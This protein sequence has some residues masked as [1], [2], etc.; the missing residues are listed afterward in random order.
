MNA[1]A[2]WKKITFLIV[3][4]L[5]KYDAIGE[6]IYNSELEKNLRISKF[7]N[8]SNVTTRVEHYIFKYY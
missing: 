2:S 8:H 7:I 3:M 1:K 6:K 4:V 5:Q